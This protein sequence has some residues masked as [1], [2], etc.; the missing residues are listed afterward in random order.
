MKNTEVL[1]EMSH[2]ENGILE[3]QYVFYRHII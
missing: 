3:E 1:M 2:W